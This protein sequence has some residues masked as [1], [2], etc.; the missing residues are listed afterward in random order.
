MPRLSLYRPNRQND[1][2]FIDRTVM[3]MYQVGGVDMFVHKYLGPQPHGDDSMKTHQG[4]L[5]FSQQALRSK[6]S[7]VV[8]SKLFLNMYCAC[9]PAQG[10]HTELPRTT[11]TMLIS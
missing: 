3:E 8:I 1:Y 2:K 9:F 11:E 5:P 7:L 4:T 10:P 6:C